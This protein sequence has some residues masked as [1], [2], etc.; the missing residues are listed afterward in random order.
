[1]SG[2]EKEFDE[3]RLLWRRAGNALQRRGAS[4]C[5]GANDLAAA[6]V[7]LHRRVGVLKNGQRIIA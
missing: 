1:M 6:L 2:S 5:P 4:A 3:A 7:A